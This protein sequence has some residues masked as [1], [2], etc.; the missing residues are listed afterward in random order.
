M[1]DK[2]N[3]ELGTIYRWLGVVDILIRFFK[4]LGIKCRNAPHI[5][6]SVYAY[7]SRCQC[8][9]P[10]KIYRVLRWGLSIA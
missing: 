3:S 8:N 10:R 9:H 2:G 5:T 4:T 7:K 1:K 6:P